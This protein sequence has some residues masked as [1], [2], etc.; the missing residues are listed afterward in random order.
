M[1]IVY[2]LVTALL[3]VGDRSRQQIIGYDRWAI[4]ISWQMSLE[5]DTVNKNGK[6][7]AS[8]N[9]SW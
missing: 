6:K 9:I 5:I 7:K 1:L 3:I 8:I 4:K 2:A